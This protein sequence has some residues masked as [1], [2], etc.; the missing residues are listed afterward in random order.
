MNTSR[1]QIA[2]GILTP[3]GSRVSFADEPPAG[4]L[5]VGRSVA[6]NERVQSVIGSFGGEI[7]WVKPL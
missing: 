3:I 2:I 1:L 5:G 7:K 6:G 4:G